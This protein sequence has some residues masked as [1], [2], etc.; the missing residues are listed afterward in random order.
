M[1]LRLST[2]VR[3]KMI[4][5][6]ATVS[7]ICAGAGE[8]LTIVDGGE[9]LADTFTRASGSFITDGFVAGDK[10]TL[11]GATTE[12]NDTA[13]TGEL[14]NTVAALTLT[15]DADIVDTGEVF[16]AATVLCAAKGGSLKDIFQNGVLNIYSG[17]QPAT[18]DAAVAGTL[19]VKLTVSSGAF[20]AGAEASGLEFGDPALGVIAKCADE[21]WSGL[22]LVAGT[23]SWF[24]LCANAA[25][26]GAADTGYI[27]P[28]ID[29]TVGVSGADAT[30]SNTQ[31]VVDAP[32]TVDTFQLTFPMQYGA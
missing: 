10:L 6:Q 26:A 8:T 24:R 28:R 23:A 22:G 11:S 32:Y 16:A 5:L 9:G 18:P 19:L 17:A 14:V 1:A 3:N 4:G 12:A 25:D 15:I 31:I 30:I 27:Y 29:G 2:A 20:V 13:V 21:V 7:A